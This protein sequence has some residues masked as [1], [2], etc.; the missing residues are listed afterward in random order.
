[1][2]YSVPISACISLIL[3]IISGCTI[4]PYYTGEQVIEE[5]QELLRGEAFFPAE[6]PLPELEQVELLAVNEDMRAF[7]DE[8]IPSPTMTDEQKTYR[9]LEALLDDG[10]NLQYENLKTYTAAQAFEHRAGNCMSFTNLFIALAR[11]VGVIASYQEVKVPPTWSAIGD[12]HYYYLHINTIVDYHSG[13]QVVVDF[14]TRMQTQSSRDTRASRI[15]VNRDRSRHVGD[16]TAAA[17]YFNN[18]AVYYLGEGELPTAFLH[19]RKAI[20]LRPNTGYFWSNMGTI[21]KRAGDLGHAEQAYLAAIH[22]DNEPA[23]VSNLARLYKQQ[24]RLDEAARY[25]A[26]AESFRARNPY[27]LYELASNAYDAG[28]Y[29]RASELLRS[30]VRKHDEHEFY[31]LLGMTWLKL[32]EAKR[33][34]RSFKKAAKYATDSEQSGLIAQK[35][36]LLASSS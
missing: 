36:R 31:R 16:G 13:K 29:E 27:Y 28:D 24:G 19:S 15:D 3:L 34:E 5:H 33:A 9:I 17:Q 32:G 4:T 2:R 8:I 18:M 20:V 22:L 12:T 10:L 35:L 25:A 7:L 14:D 21:L 30:A 11:E 23:A 26:L 6:E 1:M